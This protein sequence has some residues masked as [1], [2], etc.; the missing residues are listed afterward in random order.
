ML[1]SD[2]VSL[3]DWLMVN[4]QTD[5]IITNAVATKILLANGS[6]AL[7]LVFVKESKQL[8]PAKLFC[9]KESSGSSAFG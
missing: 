6:D 7:I 1:S 9:S 5:V 3:V 2:I 4:V 8:N